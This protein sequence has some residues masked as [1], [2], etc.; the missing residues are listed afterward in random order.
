LAWLHVDLVMIRNDLLIYSYYYPVEFRE[1]AGRAIRTLELCDFAYTL[2]LKLDA[3][4]TSPWRDVVESLKWR[5]VSFIGA[6]ND[7][8]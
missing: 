2:N 6:E 3:L 1:F 8:A 7:W 4:T 5:Y